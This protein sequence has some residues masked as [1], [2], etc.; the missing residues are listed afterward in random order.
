MD[1]DSHRAYVPERNDVI[2]VRTVRCCPE[3]ERWDKEIYD[4]LSHRP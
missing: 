1:S 4:K 2:R 3:S